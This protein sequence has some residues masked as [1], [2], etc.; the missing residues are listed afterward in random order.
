MKEI[1]DLFGTWL[2]GFTAG[3]GCF[4]INKDTRRN[5]H[6]NYTCRFVITLRDDDSPILEEIHKTL[7]IGIIRDLPAHPGNPRNAQPQTTFRVLTINDCAKLVELFEKYPLRAKK[8]QDFSIWKLAVAELQKPVDCRDP[9]LLEYYCLKIKEVRQYEI[10]KEI[11]QPIVKS[12][13]LTIEFKE[14]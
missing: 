6:I 2:A 3:E 12:L 4:L 9:D 10:Q 11:T 7:G 8:Q 14:E 5:K 13:Q 1:D